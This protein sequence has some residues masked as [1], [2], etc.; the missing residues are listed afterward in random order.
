MEEADT[1]LPEWS[2]EVWVTLIDVCIAH[3]DKTITF[4]FKS[5]HEITK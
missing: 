2:D 5:G 1:V 3:H 4:R